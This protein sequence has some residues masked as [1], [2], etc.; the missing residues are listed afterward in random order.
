MNTYIYLVRHGEVHN[1]ELIYYGRLP[2]FGLSEGGKLEIAQTSEFLKTKKINTLYSSPLLRA[3]QTAEIIKDKISLKEIHYSNQLLEVRTSYQ[4]KLFADLDPFQSEVY[5]KPLSPDDETV[6]ALAA[7]MLNAVLT[8][9]K[10]HPGQHIA[11]V[12][13][14]DP[15]MSLAALIQKWELSFPSIR[16][17][18]YIKHGE[19]RRVTIDDQKHMTIESVFEPK[20]I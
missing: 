15:L 17:G 12:S 9:Q 2:N 14:G 3:R 18:S 20:L 4:G 19:V 5:L 8:I 1:P 11:L 7:R 10:K 16:R 6:A 13:H